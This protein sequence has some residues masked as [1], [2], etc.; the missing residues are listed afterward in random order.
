[1]PGQMVAQGARTADMWGSTPSPYGAC[2]ANP[3]G[4]VVCE[5]F[6]NMV[7]CGLAQIMNDL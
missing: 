7:G 4:L 1:M 2:L 3:G 5:F 6:F